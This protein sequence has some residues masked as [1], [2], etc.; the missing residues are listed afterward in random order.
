[1]HQSL[2]TMCFWIFILVHLLSPLES[3]VDIPALPSV[4]HDWISVMNRAY[5]SHMHTPHL[6]RMD[7]LES[8]LG[9]S[10]MALK[11]WEHSRSSVHI[12]GRLGSQS[13]AVTEGWKI[14]GEL[15]VFQLYLKAKNWGSDDSEG[16]QGHQ[17]RE[18]DALISKM[19]RQAGSTISPSGECT[20]HSGEG[21]LLANTPGPD[22]IGCP[23]GLS[24]RWVQIFSG[25]QSKLPITTMQ[26]DQGL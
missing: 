1:M 18:I 3:R 6:L 13:Q 10:A 22:L 17:C 5:T 16:G 7:L 14:P 26:A 8:G 15:L 23:P 12:T 25:W 24:L 2:W 4:P 11:G 9:S 21:L 19:Y 20:A